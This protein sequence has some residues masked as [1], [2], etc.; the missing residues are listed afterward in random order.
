MMQIKH[1]SGFTCSCVIRLAWLTKPTR[2]PILSVLG[3]LSEVGGPSDSMRE[4]RLASSG[5]WA[6]P[7]GSHGQ[8][9]RY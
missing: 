9:G 3:A 4:A 7:L 2:H 8:V 1:K 5:Q 6:T